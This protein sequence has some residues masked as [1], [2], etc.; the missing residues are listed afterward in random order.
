MSIYNVGG[1]K[2]DL[3]ENERGCTDVFLYSGNYYGSLAAAE[4]EGVIENDH[5]DEKRVPRHVI[6]RV[7]ELIESENINY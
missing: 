6:K 4:Q 3:C 1:F 7:Y 5:G 2:L